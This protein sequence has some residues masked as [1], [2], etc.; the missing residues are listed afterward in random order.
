MKHSEI[1]KNFKITYKHNKKHCYI[2]S[3]VDNKWDT[4]VGYISNPNLLVNIE[5]LKTKNQDLILQEIEKIK[6]KL[7]EDAFIELQEKTKSYIDKLYNTISK[8][9]KELADN[10]YNYSVHTDYEGSRIDI[11]ILEIL[12]N[13]Y[14]KNNN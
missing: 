14:I 13:N 12:V 6:A 2:S 3:Y 8:N 11:K 7:V 5:I 9:Y 1:Y 10:I 4:D